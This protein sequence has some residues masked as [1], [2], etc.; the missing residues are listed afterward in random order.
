M[1][2]KKTVVGKIAAAAALMGPSTTLLA[3][4]FRLASQDGFA[5]GRGEAFVATADN[6]SAIYYNPAGLTQLEGQNL[7]GGFYGIYLD[8]TFKPDSGSPTFHSQDKLAAVPQLFYTYNKENCPISGGLGI[9]SPFGL[10]VHWPQ[11]TGFR[12]AGTQAS[13]TYIT[14]NPAVAFKLSDQISIGGG[15]T[16]NYADADLRQ[17]LIWPAQ[18]LD[19][20]RFAGDGWDVGYNLG[21]LVKVSEQVSL[22]ATFR[23]G[24]QVHL[25]G[26]VSDHNSTALPVPPFLP[27]FKERSSASA[28]FSFP[29]SATFGISYRP[30]PK[31]NVEFDAD[32]TDWNQVQ[33]LTIHRDTPSLVLPQNV[34]VVLDWQSSWYY[35]LGGTRY[36]DNGWHVSAGYI[37]NENSMP[38]A[39]YTPLVADQDRHFFTLGVGRKC[40]HVNFDVA[41]QFGY[42]PDR[43]VTGSAPSNAGQTADGTYGFISHAIL[44]TAGVNF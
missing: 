17:G 29:L 22:G 27:P 3:A 23:S 12:T 19:G 11:D 2:M 44:V 35:E 34:P 32:Y 36:L 14:V 6:P 15:I 28:D 41:Y 24:T 8:P 38:N 16:V 30:T 25:Q 39:H 31:W 4:G 10:K 42:G 37:F 43:K 26:H 7:R 9:Y 20:F 1:K 40:E 21:A 18:P 13:L 33:T 5:S